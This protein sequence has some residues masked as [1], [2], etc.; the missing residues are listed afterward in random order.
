MKISPLYSV[1]VPVYNSQETLE[2]LFKRTQNTFRSLKLEFEMVFVNDCSR[3]D[4]WEVL[5]NLQQSY[6]DQITT[7]HLAKNFGQHNAL[8]CAFHHIKGDFVITI[9]DDLQIPPEEIKKLINKQNQTGADVVYGIYDRKKH[10]LFRNLGSNA[11]Q[12]IFRRIF[13]TTGNITAFR[14]IKGDIIR[15]IRQHRQ[16]FVFVDGL[17]HWHTQFFDRELVKHEK[18]TFGRSGYSL[19]KLLLLTSNLLFNFTTYPLRLLVFLGT[20]FSVTSFLIGLYY[21]MRKVFY[22]VPM[23]YTSQIVSIFFSSGVILLVIGV[24]GEY[25]GRI[26]SL[27]NDKPQFSIRYSS[28]NK[29]KE[30]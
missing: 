25:I 28:S 10:S 13:K 1:V 22:D 24:V 17:L 5:Q 27:Q 8:M 4:S 30:E 16:S 14:L 20:F 2:K 21:L 19:K 23:G 29:H 12:L 11:V 9:D 26:Y 6:P 15:S 3:D 7:I 18:R